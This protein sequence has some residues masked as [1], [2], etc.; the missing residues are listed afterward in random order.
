LTIA[1]AVGGVQGSHKY[2]GPRRPLFGMSGRCSY[3]DGLHRHQI[4]QIC[5]PRLMSAAKPVTAQI[6][7]VARA[8]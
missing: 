4:N 1:A 8:D 5:A 2:V 7:G 6:G 3:V